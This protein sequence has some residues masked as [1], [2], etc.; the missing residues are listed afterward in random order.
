M[1]ELQDATVTLDNNSDKNTSFPVVNFLTYVVTE[2]VKCLIVAFN[3]LTFHKVV[4]RHTYYCKCSPDS[5]NENR[6]V[7]DEFKAYE[8]KAYKKMCQ[9]FEPPCIHLYSQQ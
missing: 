3:T 7:F 2:V 4:Q 1:L 6:S 5:E 8:V 9:F